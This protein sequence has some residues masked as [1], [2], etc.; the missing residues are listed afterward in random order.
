MRTRPRSCFQNA[1]GGAATPS[2]SSTPAFHGT[3]RGTSGQASIPATPGRIAAHTSTNGVPVTSTCGWRTCSAAR[4]SFEPST[5]WSSSTPRRRPGPGSRSRTTSVEVVHAVE[6]L[7]HHP[8]LAEVVAPHLLDQLGVVDA[9]RRGCGWRGPRGPARGAAATDPDAVT[10]GGPGRRRGGDEGGR[11]AV[12]EEAAGL[13]AEGPVDVEA[14]AQHDD[15]L[16]ERA[17]RADHAAGAVLHHEPEVGR[18]GA[19]V[20]PARAAAVEVDRVGEDAVSG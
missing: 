2:A 5:R 11:L 14:V 9:L 18:H 15:L 16:A 13:V 7:D 10:A 1:P 20:G 12:D 8:E 19:V 4:V 17:D 6:P 3:P